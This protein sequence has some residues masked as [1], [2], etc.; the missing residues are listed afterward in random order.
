MFSWQCP[1]SA[2]RRGQAATGSNTNHAHVELRAVRRGAS[3]SEPVRW[4]NEALWQCSPDAAKHGDFPAALSADRHAQNDYFGSKILINYHLFH[5]LN[6][7]P[8][9]V[10]IRWEISFE[11]SIIHIIGFFLCEHWRI[12][13]KITAARLFTFKCLYQMVSMELHIYKNERIEPITQHRRPSI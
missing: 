12:R 3:S 6:K 10:N 7:K 4:S 8:N 1:A 2:G 9:I 13:F 11:S 5:L